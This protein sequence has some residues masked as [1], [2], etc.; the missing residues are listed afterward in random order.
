VTLAAYVYP[1]W[2][3]I[4]ERDQSFHPG[5]TEWELVYG[6][7][8]RFPGH[9]QPRLPAWGRY[10]DRDPVEVGRRVQLAASHGID[11]FVY[12][13]FWC[14]GKRVFEDALDLGF[15]GSP[16]GATF[17]FAV[18]WANRMPRR[19][20]PVA[21]ADVPVI[22]PARLVSSDA[23][24]FVELIRHCARYFSR[25]SYLRI[26]GRLYFSI[27]DS[28]FFIREL[29]FAAAKDAI[30]RARRFTIDNG[31]G[32]LFLA[33]IE[34]ASDLLPRVREL[35][36]DA[37]T[38]YVSLPRWNGE[39]LQDYVE[40]AAARAAE[41]PALARSSGLPYFPSVSPGWDASPR[42]ADFGVEKP[43]KYPWWPVVVGEHPDHFHQALVRARDLRAPL[44][45]IA[46]WNEWSEGHYL[47]PDT[48]F[49]MEW[50]YAVN[51]SLPHR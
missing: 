36:F 12:G 31:L 20:L 15:L 39:L 8:P 40:S 44:T 21:R 50:L 38:H 34:P 35:G 19:V 4:A 41:W 28:S 18:M 45:L 37:V 10:D 43:R 46:S 23:D 30:V 7:R 27:F 42:G 17:P 3:P 14:R 16:E 24:D 6:C 9:V 22:D 1:G 49:G 29:G 32:D 47:E 33:A 26:G 13:L 2:H 5:F 51:R 11:A 48:R 25:P